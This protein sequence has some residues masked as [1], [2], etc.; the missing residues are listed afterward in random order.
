MTN[1]FAHWDVMNFIV[2]LKTWI[3]EQPRKKNEIKT[4]ILT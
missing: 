4:L 1:D 2:D 3:P